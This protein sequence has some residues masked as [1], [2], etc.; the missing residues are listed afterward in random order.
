MKSIYQHLSECL[1][2]IYIEH[3]VVIINVDASWT[4]TEAMGCKVSAHLDSIAIG[5][6]RVVDPD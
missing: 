4:Y 1:K 6:A 2:A 5:D 3:G